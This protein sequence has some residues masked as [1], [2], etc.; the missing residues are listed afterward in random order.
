MKTP[1]DVLKELRRLSSPE[2]KASQEYFGLNSR[3]SYGLRT[4]QI[5]QVA[6]QIG[7]NHELALQLWKTGVHEARHVAI[8]IADPKLATEKFMEGW[9]K[10]FDSWDLVDN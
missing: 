4:P 8:F 5:R 9:L 3:N 10:D 2:A 7:K 6:K 1:E